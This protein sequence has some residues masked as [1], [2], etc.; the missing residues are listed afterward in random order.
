MSI[1]LFG[2]VVESFS[3]RIAFKEIKELNTEK[4]PLFKFLKES[5][6]S[7]ILIIFAED[8]C[9]VVGLIIAMAG[10]IL[11]HITGNAMFDAA[12]GLLIGLMLCMAALFLAREFYSLLIGESMTQKDLTVLHCAFERSEINKLINVKTIHL[13]PTDI[14]VTAKIEFT[15]AAQDHASTIINDIENNIR[16]SFP[17]YKLY[18]YIETDTFENN[19]K[20]KHTLD[21]G[22]SKA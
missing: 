3:L 11:T 18:I 19:Y 5:R 2:M 22:T 7:E 8:T 13:S 15:S 10:T 16:H 17:K 21:Y 12:S 20:E 1:L 4:L 9:A 14:L 6:H